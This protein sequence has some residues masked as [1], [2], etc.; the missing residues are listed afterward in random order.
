MQ[1]TGTVSVAR[2][3]G[4]R[5]KRLL[6]A[7]ALVLAAVAPWCRRCS[8][9]SSTAGSVRLDVVAAATYRRQLALRPRR[10][11][12]L[13][14]PAR[15][16]RCAALLVARGGGA[17][18]PRVAVAAA[19]RH[20]AR[21]GTVA[22]S[23]RAA[24]PVSRSP[25]WRCLWSAG[26]DRVAGVGVLLGI[27]PRPGSRRRRS[28][29]HGAAA[30][31]RAHARAPATLSGRRRRARRRSVLTLPDA[32]AF[33]GTRGAGA[34]AGTAALV[35]RVRLPDAVA[36]RLLS[37]LLLVRVGQGC[38]TPG[39]CGAGR[40]WS[41]PAILVG[42]GLVVAGA[43][44]RGG[45][46]YVVAVVTYASSRSHVPPLA[47]AGLYPD[48]ALPRRGVHGRRHRRGA[49]SRRPRGLRDR[50]PVDA[51]RGARCH[52]ARRPGQTRD[53]FATASPAAPALPPGF[54]AGPSPS[55]V[56]T[57]RRPTPDGC[58]Q[59]V[60]RRAGVRLRRP[61]GRPHGGALRRLARR[62][63]VPRRCARSCPAGA[64]GWCRSRR[65]RARSP[66]RGLRRGARPLVP[67]CATRRAAAMARI[68]RRRSRPR[69][70]PGRTDHQ[71][72]MRSAPGSAPTSQCSR[73]P[74]R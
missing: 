65:T 18:L 12:L 70:L 72:M 43:A 30:R 24:R 51:G 62:H 56:T 16:P 13:L 2:F 4:R 11:R 33:P 60:H 64:G 73:S 61:E 37:H 27:H 67:R 42:G 23:P 54:G 26:T 49:R 7:T 39:T 29:R 50:H 1:S 63:L 45:L 9:R 3:C 53:V 44:G 57:C 5:A 69:R 55:C 52:R 22:R 74:T 47:R 58:H 19:R 20:A 48:R 36:S 40:C 32:M 41:S 66:R 21:A 17:V 46:S 8:S 34:G 10:R 35:R 31:V 71:V 28:P 15:P 38:R 25:R 59:R 68:A 14:P 6:P